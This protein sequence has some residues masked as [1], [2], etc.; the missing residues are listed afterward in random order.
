LEN[1]LITPDKNIYLIDFLD[2]FFDSRMID[3]AK[4]LQ[5]LETLRSYRHQKIDTTLSLRLSIAKQA[6]IENIIELPN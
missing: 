1:V 5:D 6:L 3:A 4:I 2:S